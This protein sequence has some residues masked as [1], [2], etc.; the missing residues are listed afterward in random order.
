VFAGT[1]SI[2]PQSRMLSEVNNFGTG[3]VWMNGDVNLDIEFLFHEVGHNLGMA[4]ADVPGHCDLYDQCDHTCPMGATGGQGIRCPNAPHLWQVR[5][6]LHLTWGLM[7][8]PCRS[9]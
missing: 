5:L 7:L 6:E 4:H 3:V 2:G 1:A 9:R 8:G